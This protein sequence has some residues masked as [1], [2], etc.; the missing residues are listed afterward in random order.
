MKTTIYV[1]KTYN[2]LSGYTGVKAY[3]DYED[4]REWF[5]KK[6]KK[7]DYIIRKY[8][9]EISQFSSCQGRKDK[10]PDLIY[11]Y[12]IEKTTLKLENERKGQ[13]ND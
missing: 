9:D 11:C 2:N 12:E 8:D 10:H 4:A 5:L 3:E 13:E 7:L 1:A 6:V